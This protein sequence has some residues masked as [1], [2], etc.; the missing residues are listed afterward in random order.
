MRHSSNE[1]YS[2]R[3]DVS[4]ATSNTAVPS[5]SCR[6]HGKHDNASGDSLSST[7][8]MGERMLHGEDML[9]PFRSEQG[10]QMLL[11]VM[12]SDSYESYMS[13][14]EQFLT[15]SSP[16]SCGLAT[17]AMVLNSL[18]V[19][20]G[21]VWRKPWRWFTEDTLISCFQLEKSEKNL[22]LTMEHFAL[23]AECNG[24][25][26]QTFYGSETSLDDFRKLVESVFTSPLEKRFVVA[27][28]RRILGQTGTGHYSPLGAYHKES[29][30]L[31]VLD[32]ARFKYPPY[33]VPLETMWEATRTIDPESRRTR[34]CFVL[35]RAPL[36][37]PNPS[38]EVTK[39]NSLANA[40]SDVSNTFLKR[41][42]AEL[43][44]QVRKELLSCP[45]IGDTCDTLIDCSA[46]K[47]GKLL[48]RELSRMSEIQSVVE[49]DKL[50]HK[51]FI[52]EESMRP[53]D[54]IIQSM[55]Q[56][57][58]QIITVLVIKRGPEFLGEETIRKLLGTS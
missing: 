58:N 10:K 24:S 37:G 23:I 39:Y 43:V 30:M 28:D 45:C 29:D 40:L 32:V 15:Q 53:I 34:G 2:T 13:L 12:Q 54:I 44:H 14:T 36:T 55:P 51:V 3:K 4:T 52:S 20:P 41:V 25:T 8:Y 6:R 33:W 47:G 49:A 9:I 17:L 26:A 57:V 7:F 42:V 22:G 38:E 5:A 21:R 56:F 35:S 46:Y 18:R 50:A 16:P 1:A 48:L 11:D 31:L 19:D 27:F